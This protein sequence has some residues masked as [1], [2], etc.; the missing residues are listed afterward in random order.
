MKKRIIWRDT[1]FMTAE[2][3]ESWAQDI[4]A[5]C[6][7]FGEEVPEGYA[8]SERIAEDNADYLDDERAHFEGI[9]LPASILCIGDIGRWNG[10]VCGYREFDDLESCLYSS[11]NGISYC[12]WYVDQYGNFRGTEAHHDATNYYLYRMWKP[13][14]TDEQRE[15][16]MDKIYYGKATT[17]DIYRY[18]VRLGDYIGA[19]Y[20][21][22]FSG[23]VPACV[24]A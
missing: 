16:L 18:T 8:M 15:N 2:E 5:N 1:A 22:K 17:A 11:V 3:L 4:R 24:R 10:R 7:D 6:E 23:K 21:W 9:D 14:T 20:G 12:E 19:E 13:E